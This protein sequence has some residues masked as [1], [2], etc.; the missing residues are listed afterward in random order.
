M[1][2]DIIKWNWNCL[3]IRYIKKLIPIWVIQFSGKF[4]RPPRRD[5]PRRFGEIRTAAA[6]TYVVI[7]VGCA[8][9]LYR[10]GA[11]RRDATVQNAGIWKLHLQNSKFELDSNADSS[12]IRIL[13]NVDGRGIHNLYKHINNSWLKTSDQNP[14]IL[15]GFQ[16]LKTLELKSLFSSR[17]LATIVL[18]CFI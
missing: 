2:W 1:I 17:F 15:G 12:K 16:E 3:Y 5:A 10:R 11:S 7:A 4:H 14:L 9:A 13:L 8:A 6:L 18:L